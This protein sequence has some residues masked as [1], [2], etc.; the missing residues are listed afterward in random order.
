V[1]PALKAGKTPTVLMT[2]GGQLAGLVIIDLISRYFP[3]VKLVVLSVDTLHLFPETNALLET[4]KARYGI[5]LR[6]YYPQGCTT[7]EEFNAKFGSWETLSPD[8]FGQ[9]SKVEPYVRAMNELN[10][11]PV[12][13][14]GRRQDQGGMRTELALY[15]EDK[16]TLNPLSSWTWND[17]SSYIIQYDVPCC[18]LHSQVYVSPIPLPHKFRA[19]YGT[20]VELDRPYFSLS[21]AEVRSLGEHVYVWKSFGD[22]HSSAPVLWEEEER[23]GRFFD[24]PNKTE[25]G[26]HLVQLKRQLREKKEEAKVVVENVSVKE[27]SE[28]STIKS[29]LSISLPIPDKDYSCGFQASDLSLSLPTPLCSV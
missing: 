11:I 16:R 10:D 19:I 29:D 7:V 15:E 26:I 21:E 1:A 3:G 14:T 5:D 12:Q 22:T 24:D 28:V 2:S 9:Y 17:V 27:K 25:C 18:T 20:K 8:D 4:L 23:A 6:V 13:I